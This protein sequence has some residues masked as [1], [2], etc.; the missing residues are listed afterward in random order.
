MP[1]ATGAAGGAM[2]VPDALPLPPGV[3][4]ARRATRRPTTGARLRDAG[5]G[6]ATRARTGWRKECDAGGIE[7]GGEDGGVGSQ[8]IADD[9][10]FSFV[11]TSFGGLRRR[12]SGS[13]TTTAW[14]PVG[15]SEWRR[16]GMGFHFFLSLRKKQ[17]TTTAYI[18]CN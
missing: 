14:W 11:L 3:P 16:S 6:E 15:C 12:R 4:S 1:S 18:D 7:L 13:P 8:Q 5:L 9:F 2:L 10:T 17:A